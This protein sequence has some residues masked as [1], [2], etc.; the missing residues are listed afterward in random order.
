MKTRLIEL[1][2]G[3]GGKATDDLVTEV[4][5]R[6]FNN[7]ALNRKNDQALLDLPPGR[8][9]MAC[10]SHVITP[11]FFPGGDIGTLSVTGTIN[12]V[13]MAGAVPV[14]LS[15]AF[16]LEEGFP[17]DDLE[18]IAASMAREAREAGVPIVTGDTK[19][20]EKGSGDGVFI[21]TTGIGVV[22][23]G[24][25][26]SGDR[27]RPGDRLLVSGT[28]GDHGM[29]LLA[30]REGM[31]FDPPLLS[32]CQSLHQL[33]G[34]M[35]EGVPSI[36]CLRDPTRGGVGA[37]LNEWAAQSGVGIRIREE[38]LP[39]RETVFS[40][41]ELLGLDPLYMANEGK[42]LAVCPPEDAERLLEIMKSHPQGQNAAIIGEI[43]EDR[44][45]FVEVET[46]MGGTRLLHWIHGDQLPRIC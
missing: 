40:A 24:L 28:I 23:E 31:S 9:V 20:V 21:S 11:L 10:D 25:V 37:A 5:F 42:L 12:D 17:V 7:P 32:D 3:S 4:F 2:H 13:A 14:A 18:R 15:A 33:V 46:L 34:R 8:I 41:C 19:V 27:C 35:V 29:A 36:R 43:V 39:I 16:I 22:P 45:H 26:L 6:A 1:A 30:F 38:S 44:G